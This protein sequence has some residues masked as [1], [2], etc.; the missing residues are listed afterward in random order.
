MHNIERAIK[1]WL[2][3]SSESWRCT[4]YP[5]RQVS[6]SRWL[7]FIN[8]LLHNIQFVHR[9]RRWD[10]AGGAG[11]SLS[12]F[13]ADPPAPPPVRTHRYVVNI[14]ERTNGISDLPY[15]TLSRNK[16]LC[17]LSLHKPRT[18]LKQLMNCVSKSRRL[19]DQ[20]CHYNNNTLAIRT[21][22]EVFCHHLLLT[23]VAEFFSLETQWLWPNAF[24]LRL[25]EMG[26]I[27]KL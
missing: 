1:T 9:W 27:V 12:R 8:Q 16:P 15:F 4:W 2:I 18:P 25:G 11:R 20:L 22:W 13:P 21:L 14:K 19:A 26:L 6:H 17:A 7:C 5:L 3:R 24:N 10:S 23:L